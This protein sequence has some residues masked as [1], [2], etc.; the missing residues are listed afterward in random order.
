MNVDRYQSAPG[1][2]QTRRADE[3][4]KREWAEKQG[5]AQAQEE[6][7]ARKKKKALQSL[8]AARAAVSAQKTESVKINPI[9][10]END[11]LAVEEG[12][13]VAPLRRNRADATRFDMKADLAAFV[14]PPLM[15]RTMIE[16]DELW[17]TGR[18]LLEYLEKIEVSPELVKKAARLL[19]E[20]QQVKTLLTGYRNALVFS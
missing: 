17:E 7:L 12:G 5:K 1:V 18:Q 11:S 16:K 19:Q 15:S 14:R 4:A 9:K 8:R 20:E 13:A 10:D 2:M 3:E 6:G